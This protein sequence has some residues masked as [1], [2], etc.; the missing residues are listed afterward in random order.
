MVCGG[1]SSDKLGGGRRNNIVI[2]Y[3]HRL[4]CG[5]GSVGGVR[6]WSRFCCGFD[7]DDDGWSA[8]EVGFAS[9]LSP[10]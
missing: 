4:I 8:G 9:L 2:M 6:G 5:G 1:S 10:S 3:H 7:I